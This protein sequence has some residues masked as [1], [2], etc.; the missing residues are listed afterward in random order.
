VALRDRHALPQDLCDNID[1]TSYALGQR[2]APDDTPKFLALLNAE[3]SDPA[4]IEDFLIAPILT[5]CPRPPC[6]KQRQIG[7]SPLPNRRNTGT[8]PR[9]T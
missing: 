1:T 2:L 3:R 9:H 7:Q 8:A 6:R 5:F 4:I